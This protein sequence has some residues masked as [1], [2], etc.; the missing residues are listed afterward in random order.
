MSAIEA[1]NIFDEHNNL[2]LTHT[3]TGRP[4]PPLVL[5]PLYLQHAAPRPS[6][7]Y[8][9]SLHPPTVL[10]SIVQDNLLFFSPSSGIDTEPL[11]V[12]EFLHRVADALEEFLGS[13]LLASKIASTYDIVAQILAE[14]AD[15][16]VVCH[17]EA[18]ALRDV[19]ET[20]PGVLNNLLGKGGGPMAMSGSGGGI[21]RTSSGLSALQPAQTAQGSAISW[22]RN[23]VKHTSNE[24]YVDLVETLSVTLAPSGRLLSAFAY[25]SIAFTSKV[26]GVPD[27]LLSLSTGG[28]GAGMGN[29]GDQLRAVM[30]RTVFHP[31][32]R[33][34]RW[35]SEGVMSF[36]PPDGR[37][38]LCGYEVDLLGPEAP[39]TAGKSGYGSLGLPAGVE[40]T[41]GQG[42]SGNEFEVRLTQPTTSGGGASIATASL[43]SNLS[44]GS[45]IGNRLSSNKPGTGTGDSKA[46]SLDKLTVR[47]PLPAAVRNV[48]EL[49]PSKGEA[50]WSPADGS[51]EWKVA[52]KDF[53]PL[54]AVLRCTIQGP[55][56]ADGDNAGAVL[57]GMTATTYDYNDDEPTSAYQTLDGQEKQSNGVPAQVSRE[58]K[59]EKSRELMPTSATLSFGVKGWLASGLRVESLLLDNKKSRGLGPEVKPYKGVKYLTVSRE[60]IELRC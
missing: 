55:L 52:A 48:T 41:T 27:L 16:G 31:C 19:V 8:L 56:A 3:Y 28:K 11:L 1:V 20:G 33:L 34:G 12:L 10:Y 35:K 5:L 44:G 59:V 43:Q 6:V 58:A 40:I 29:R 21:Q 17:G 4:S 45:G 42:S 24:L 53:G 30:E 57:N 7:L 14:V 25:G 51:V 9:P 38:A 39:L 22:R 18:N 47:V 13:P 15:A 37:F 50:H 49:R 36:V 46:P 60:G 32:V 23:N 54:G 2:L 26:S